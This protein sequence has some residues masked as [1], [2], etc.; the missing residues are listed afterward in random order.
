ML[1]KLRHFYFLIICIYTTSIIAQPVNLLPPTFA[2]DQAIPLN[3]CG[4][5]LVQPKTDLEELERME[6]AYV[7]NALDPEI[8]L[9]N[10]DYTLPIV[11][12]VV[13]ENGLENI[14]NEQIR[15]GIAQLNQ[16]FSN[17]GYFSSTAG[18]PTSF[19]FCLAKQDPDGNAT[20]GIN[21]VVSDLTELNVEAEDASLKNTIRWDTERYI[22]VWLVKEIC[23]NSAGC[24]VA[25]YAYLPNAHGTDT[26][27]IVMEARWLGTNYAAYTTVLIH[28]V[29]HYLGLRHTF[30]GGCVNDNC[31][32]A[33]DRVCDTPPDQTTAPVPCDETVNSCDTDVNSSDTN[34]PFNKDENDLLGNFMDYGDWDCYIAFTQGQSD[35]MDFFLKEVRSSLINSVACDD[36]CPQP[37]SAFFEVDQLN[38]ETG[39]EISFTNLSQNASTYTWYHNGFPISN[40][41]NINY[42]F[43]KD[44]VSE[45]ILEATSDDPFCLQQRY[46]L[47]IEVTC[48]AMVSINAS[49]TEIT[50][51][52]I[53]NFTSTHSSANSFSWYVN[54]DLEGHDEILD[55]EFKQGGYYEIYLVTANEFCEQRSN[56]ILVEVDAPC[57]TEKK[58]AYKV[59]EE[60]GSAWFG[61]AALTKDGGCIFAGNNIILK[62]D[63][64]LHDEWTTIFELEDEFRLNHIEVLKND[65]GYVCSGTFTKSGSNL[66]CIFMID[67]DGDILW[68]RMLPFDGLISFSE[69]LETEDGG[70]IFVGYDTIKL[71]WSEGYIVKL[72][73]Q[74]DIVWARGYEEL[75]FSNITFSTLALSD[76]GSILIGGVYF[77]HLP[78]MAWRGDLVLLKINKEGELNWSKKYLLNV[79]DYSCNL[80]LNLFVK[81]DGT[82]IIS[83][84]MEENIGPDGFHNFLIH[85]NENGSLLN[86]KIFDPNFYFALGKSSLT[87]DGNILYTCNGFF[88][89][90]DQDFNYL[91]G[92]NYR[93]QNVWP[94]D[95][96]ELPDESLVFCG[97][98]HPGLG[99]DASWMR[100]DRNGFM[101]NCLAGT[102][103]LGEDDYVISEYDLPLKE[104]EYPVVFKNIDY[105]YQQVDLS[106]TRVC[107]PIEYPEDLALT[108]FETISCP[109]NTTFNLQICN[110]GH[111]PASPDI[112]ITIYDN[113]PTLG[114]A[115]AMITFSIGESIPVDSCLHLSVKN[116][117]T[118]D[119]DR[120]YALLNDD[121][122]LEPPFSL[123]DLPLTSFADCDF[124]N[125]ITATEN[126]I[127]ES[128]ELD[129]G[130]DVNWC[131]SETLWLEAGLYDA[132]QWSTGDTLAQIQITSPGTYWVETNDFCGTQKDTIS[133]LPYTAIPLD[134]GPDISVC[135]NN[136]QVFDA[137][138][139][140]QSYQWNDFSKEQLLTAYLPGTYWVEVV[141][142]CAWVQRDTI[143][144]SIDAAS[145]FEL[146][147][148]TTLCQGDSLS[149]SVPGFN[150]YQWKPSQG[151]DCDTCESVIISPTQSTLYT[152]IASNAR[153]CIS[154]DKIQV[155]LRTPIDCDPFNGLDTLMEN[156]VFQVFPNP[157]FGQVTINIEWAKATD[158][159]IK[160]YN[161]LG[162]LMAQN[163][164]SETVL[165][166]SFDWSDLASGL[167]LVQLVAPD[168]KSTK[169]I[170]LQRN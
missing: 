125:N 10:S 150:S 63:S 76:D 144:L 140:Y 163:F 123:G 155:N 54:G 138:A 29:G 148:D 143:I 25:G 28:E 75:G 112:P 41:F 132:Y 8:D 105:T 167:Y 87:S 80:G 36:P 165:Q 84:L 71:P 89:K 152:L 43:L 92:R 130:A 116:Q 48:S 24:N 56:S 137:G 49:A 166:T 17:T 52:E 142:G 74:G 95:G 37:I 53:I 157:S 107:P 85:I 16:A 13:H 91:W 14:S 97:L 30:L 94:I 81:E 73:Q 68:E 70:L 106:A 169:K 160:L 127:F 99:S 90:M 168:F 40:D 153:N 22:N 18:V 72:N 102:V 118:F 19:Q 149:L 34:N 58:Y 154:V 129:L 33:G 161:V 66:V 67:L 117:S 3:S 15:L 145:Q 135:E 46:S 59:Y 23:S 64:L 2:N 131:P 170:I 109:N 44:G 126:V 88:F 86:T 113:N 121:A 50:E 110:H 55:Y 164:Y 96:L 26:D 134:L 27:G 141:D 162:Q 51:G 100:T 45:I 39:Q 21:R 124:Y 47:L 12:H 104:L 159:E 82:Y 147:L 108:H 146:G 6:T 79:D 158:F 11:V 128:Q 133:Y 38:I 120:V 83:G 114:T 7:K 111:T 78:G 5:N 119:T 98:M 57:S 93:S 115:N 32:T 62:K 9:L 1:M 122:S 101:P 136:I 156:L 60:E 42:T 103:F 20:I 61:S 151:I 69:V 4:L 139:N 35:R 65:K 77:S 31:L